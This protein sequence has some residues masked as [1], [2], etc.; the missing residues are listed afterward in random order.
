MPPYMTVAC[1]VLR[2]RAE[3]L[4]A[5]EN[6]LPEEVLDDVA[7]RLI[8]KTASGNLHMKNAFLIY[9]TA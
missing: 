3:I 4:P 7:K 2:I 8:K 1:M 5:Y 6:V 9:G